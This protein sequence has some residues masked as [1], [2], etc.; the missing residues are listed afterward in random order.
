MA[1]IRID[2]LR[3]VLWPLVSSGIG[4]KGREPLRPH[5]KDMSLSVCTIASNRSFSPCSAPKTS[6]LLAPNG[7][8]YHRSEM[9]AVMCFCLRLF[10]LPFE[11]K[12]RLEAESDN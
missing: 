6:F 7:I 2:R 12:I 5:A 11:S 10:T 8:I 4:A 1:Q 9:T 3:I